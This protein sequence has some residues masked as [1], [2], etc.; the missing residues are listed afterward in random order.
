MAYSPLMDLKG[1]THTPIPDTS[2]SCQ[3]IKTG[4]AQ[5]DTTGG[6]LEGT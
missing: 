3:K 2:Q 4:Q 1:K 5:I 6:S